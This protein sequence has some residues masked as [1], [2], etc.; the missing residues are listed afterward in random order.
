MKTTLTQEF[1]LPEE[2]SDLEWATHV[3]EA[4]SLIWDFDRFIRGVSRGKGPRYDTAE[5]A[6]EGITQEWFSLKEALGA[7]LDA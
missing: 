1:D 7:G 4:R 2:Q 6:V 3:S 5:A